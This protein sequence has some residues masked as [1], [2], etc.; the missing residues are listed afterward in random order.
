[1]DYAAKAETLGLSWILDDLMKRLIGAQH[2][3][4]LSADGLLIG[5]SSSLDRERG[6]HL[7]AMAS[8]L[9]SLARSVGSTFDKGRVHQTVIE[10]EGGYLVV[11]EAGEGACLA[12]LASATA[13]LGMMAYEMNV[14]VQQVGP[15]FS[16]RPRSSI[17]QPSHSS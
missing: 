15:V 3:V 9:R 6:E 16:T 7:A 1:M 12:L 5:R 10:L 11:T 8:A 4:V 2:G 17:E 14:I 13:D